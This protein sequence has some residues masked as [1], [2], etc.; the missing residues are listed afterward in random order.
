MS[1]LAAFRTRVLLMLGDTGAA[2]YSNDA[3]DEALKQALSMYSNAYPGIDCQEITIAAAG[4]DQ[5]LASC[6]SFMNLIDF[7][8]PYDSSTADPLIFSGSFYMYWK[9][10]MPYLHIGGSR[11]PAAAEKILVNF[12][13][14]HAIEDL[15]SAEATTIRGDHESY[16]VIGA[17]GIAAINRG[18]KVAEAYGSQASDDSQL[19]VWGNQRLSSFQVILNNLRISGAP[20]PSTGFPG[21]SPHW[22]LDKWDRAAS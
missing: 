7:V 2:R 6:V 9:A 21:A 18:M 10:G 22:E 4:R 20:R 14:Y 5:S 3:I 12:S 13:A 8:Y 11:V 19:L 17:A 16:L 15:D 1:A